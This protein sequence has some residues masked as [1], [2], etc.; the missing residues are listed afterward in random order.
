LRCAG[1]RAADGWS[2]TAQF[3]AEAGYGP[4]E[5]AQLAAEGVIRLGRG[6]ELE[7]ELDK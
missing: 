4:D 6:K 3:L 5:I 2:A 1:W 7:A